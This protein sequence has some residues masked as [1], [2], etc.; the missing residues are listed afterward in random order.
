[1][2]Y[3]SIKFINK[4]KSD[5]FSALKE[6][7]D[8][9]FINNSLSK[10]GGNKMLIKAVF[11]LSLYLIPYFLI[12]SSLFSMAGMFLLSV[13]MGVGIAGVGMSI[14]HD[15]NHGSFSSKEWINKLFSYSIVL[16]GGNIYSWKLQ[17][18]TLHHTYTNIHEV[19][20]DIT[21]KFLLRFSI[22]T[23]LKKI[24]K[25]QHIYAF[26]LY[27]LMTIS[28]LVKDFRQVFHLNKKSTNDLIKPYPFKELINLITGKL[29]YFTFIMAIPML[30]THINFWQWLLGFMV[31]HFTAGLILSIIFQMA[32]IVEGVEQPL[33]D[34]KGNI[35]NAWAIHQL[36]TTSN[37]SGNNK[38]LSWFI[39]GLDFQIEHHLFPNISHIH[40]RNISGIVK[41][42]AENYGI[43]YNAK[44]SL[45]H[46]II[47]HTK[48]LKKM[49][50]E[51][52]FLIREKEIAAVDLMVLEE[53]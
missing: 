32:H 52:N 31:M 46:A 50:N 24:H 51:L 6:K 17:H 14:M 15:A 16:L 21:G 49:G 9:Y 44:K 30:L 8:D 22:E 10:T 48:M 40:Y 43:T 4:D 11:M 42:T 7:I 5:F 12:I 1:M 2:S 13:L 27:G 47:S 3:S 53:A 35:M 18:N 29:F 38:I 45:G 39:G 37:F 23:K 41:S 20:E 36:Q 26:F 28:F 34:E 33:P 19:D 25:Y